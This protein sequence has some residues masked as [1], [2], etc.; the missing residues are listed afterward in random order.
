MNTA[1]ASVSCPDIAFADLLAPE[2]LSHALVFGPLQSDRLNGR[3]EAVL[4]GKAAYEAGP[5]RGLEH[6]HPFVDA[7]TLRAA[8]V[9]FASGK[10]G[11]SAVKQKNRAPI[12]FLD[13]DDVLC[14][15]DKYGGYDV[16]DA[17]KGRH[18]SA[19]AVFRDVFSHAACDT[20][21]QIHDAMEG[22]VRYVISSTWREKFDREQLGDVFRRCGCDFIAASIHEAWRTPVN[23]PAGERGNDIAQWLDRHLRGEPFAIVD[24]TYSGLSLQPALTDP[25][26]PFAGRV[27][28]CQERVGLLPEHIEP[29]LNGLRQPL[30]S[31]TIL[32]VGDI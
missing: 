25:S 21:K 16:I 1:T 31:L 4:P 10:R 7:Q 29:L 27:V 26:H 22:S 5:R 28:L 14:L 18:R 15:N 20:L 17:L 32:P 2:P 23:K 13:I 9:T 30:V 6:H 12:L 8:S 24:D 11:Q 3:P 19:E